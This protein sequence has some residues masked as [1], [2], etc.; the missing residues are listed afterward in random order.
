[1]LA[2]VDG[3]VSLTEIAL[4]LGIGVREVAMVVARLSELGVV[5]HELDAGWG[6]EREAET[7]PPRE[8]P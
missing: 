5:D 3:V 2:L 1:M 7:V 6:N 8:A 4:G